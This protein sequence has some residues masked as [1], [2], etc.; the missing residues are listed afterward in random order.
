MD[1]HNGEERGSTERTPPTN[2]TPQ[3][4]SMNQPLHETE[5]K[6]YRTQA[7]IPRVQSLL[8]KCLS[9]DARERAVHGEYKHL[10]AKI[11]DKQRAI[12]S[13]A[14]AALYTRQQFFFK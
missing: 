11:Y 10:Q 7:A 9:K 1:H 6:H 4:V 8:L 5:D 3:L 2:A 12:N 14:R 13:V